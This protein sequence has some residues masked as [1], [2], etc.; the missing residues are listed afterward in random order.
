MH[1]L[2]S[3]II[4]TAYGSAFVIGWKYIALLDLTITPLLFYKITSHWL[5]T[6]ATS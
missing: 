5:L 6:C 4:L 2:S 1:Y 3:N